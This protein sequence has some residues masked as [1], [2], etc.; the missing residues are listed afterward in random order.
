MKATLVEEWLSPL[1]D[2]VICQPD[3]AFLRPTSPA[4]HPD[5]VSVFPAARPLPHNSRHSVARLRAWT[6]E[7]AASAFSI[8]LSQP[9]FLHQ[10]DGDK[11]KA[12]LV[13]LGGLFKGVS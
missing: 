7:L 12:S 2:G 3:P 13:G 9:P 5:R 1:P 4:G 6:L 8:S 10:Y 11:N